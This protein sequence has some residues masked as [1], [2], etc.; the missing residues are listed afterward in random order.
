MTK[1]HIYMLMTLTN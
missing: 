1:S